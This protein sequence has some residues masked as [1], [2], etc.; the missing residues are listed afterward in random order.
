VGNSSLRN[1]MNKRKEIQKCTWKVLRDCR[2][3]NSI[4]LRKK[5]VE[6]KGSKQQ[7]WQKEN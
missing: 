1:I 3:P 7:D 6:G 4:K 5:T 2:L